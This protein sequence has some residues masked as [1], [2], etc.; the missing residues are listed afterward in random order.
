MHAAKM[1]ENL[2]SCFMDVF[3]WVSFSNIATTFM[4]CNIIMILIQNIFMYA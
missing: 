4:P 3:G 1:T 2:L